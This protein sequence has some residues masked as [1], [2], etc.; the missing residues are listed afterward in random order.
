MKIIKNHGLG[1]TL[2]KAAQWQNLMNWYNKMR[3]QPAQPEAGQPAQAAPAQQQPAQNPDALRQEFYQLYEQHKQEF[4]WIKNITKNIANSPMIQNNPKH[5][6]IQDAF[7]LYSNNL[8]LFENNPQELPGL[9]QDTNEVLG[10]L[11]N[12]QQYWEKTTQDGRDVLNG[13]V[14][15]LGDFQNVLS[16]FPPGLAKLPPMQQ[17]NPQPSPYGAGYGPA[18]VTNMPAAPAQNAAPGLSTMSPADR[19]KQYHGPIDEQLKKFPGAVKNMPGK[20]KFPV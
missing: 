8:A 17:S 10:H 2:E 6:A 9:I 18:P 1:D 16:Q 5:K 11:Q 15:N 19:R 4:D 12:F 14:Q 13:W 7:A 3:G 20:N